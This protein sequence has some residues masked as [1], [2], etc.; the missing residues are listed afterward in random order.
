MRVHVCILGY[1]ENVLLTM[2]LQGSSKAIVLEEPLKD[3]VLTGSLSIL[4]PYLTPQRSI[5]LNLHRRE[6]WGKYAG[7]IMS[8]EGDLQSLIRQNCRW[9]SRRSIQ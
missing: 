7:W 5:P 4:Q 2:S 1:N 8:L 6:G 9:G 3:P